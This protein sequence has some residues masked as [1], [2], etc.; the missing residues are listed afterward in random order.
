MSARILPLFFVSTLA[1][2][3]G[4][5][6]P[7]QSGGTSYTPTATDHAGQAMTADSLTTSN[8]TTAIVTTGGSKTC[9]NG[10]SCTVAASYNTG[11]G[12]LDFTAALNF[13]GGI[14]NGNLEINGGV[15]NLKAT[16]TSGTCASSTEGYIRRFPSTG[17]SSGTRLKVCICVGDGVGAYL[18]RNIISGTDGT[19]TT[20]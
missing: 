17:A 6:P 7:A 1:L 3:A 16:S 9:Y 18:W 14:S 10:S 13:N 2:G 5:A 20:C 12:R 19:T 11:S 8:A 4:V 15:I